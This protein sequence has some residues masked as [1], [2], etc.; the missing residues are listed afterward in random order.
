MPPTPEWNDVDVDLGLVHLAECVTQRLDGA[1]DIGLDYEVEVPD[2]ALL[3]PR[4]EVVEGDP[5]LTLVLHETLTQG[6]VFGKVA[7]IALVGEHTE[8][9]A[10]GRNT[11]KAE[12]LDRVR[13]T[14]AVYDVSH[15]VD[16]RADAAPWLVPATTESPTCKVPRLTSTVATGPRPLS[17]LASMT[18]PEASVSG[19]AVSSSM[20]ACSKYHLKQLVDPDALLG[21]DVSGRSSCRPTPRVTISCS[22]EHLLDLLGVRAVLVDLVDG[23]DDR[24]ASRPSRGGWPPRSAALTPSSAATTRMTMFS[25]VGTAGTHGRERL[26]CARCVDE[27]G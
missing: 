17:S 2:V 8:L 16:E 21:G 20:S 3:D 6:A 11:R 4:E 24:H 13:R 9:I 1:L 26:G 18:T 19:F 5:R 14:R 22:D 12:D 23:D 25:D 27:R 15:G 7:C 10:G